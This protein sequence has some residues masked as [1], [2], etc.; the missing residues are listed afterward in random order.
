MAIN[1]RLYQETDTQ[2][3]AHLYFDAVRNGTI[4]FYST[5]QREAW[6]RDI[7]DVSS[8]TTRLARVKTFVAEKEG[9]IAGFMTMDNTGYIDLA[10]VRSD[11]IG[12]GIGSI[13]YGRV[14]DEAVHLGLPLL[15]TQASEMAKPFFEKHG[16]ILVK[17]QTINRD[18]I[19][20]TNHIMEKRL[21]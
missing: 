19:K 20:L 2:V 14:Y 18:K 10:F 8:W 12:K 3:L 13:L 17:T 16:W 15:H 4:E 7:P 9:V 6:A 5:E 1:V 11:F 21:S